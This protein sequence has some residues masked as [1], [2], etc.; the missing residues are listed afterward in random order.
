MIFS[1]L[2]KKYLQAAYT[3]RIAQS[4]NRLIKEDKHVAPKSE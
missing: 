1:L 3:N 4:E 2:N